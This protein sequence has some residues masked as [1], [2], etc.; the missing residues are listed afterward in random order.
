MLENKKISKSD[1]EQAVATPIDDGLQPLQH[2]STNRK[3][4]DNY[5]KEVIAEVEEKTGKNVYTDGLDIYTNLDMAAQQKLYDIINTG[6]Y[7][8]VS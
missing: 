6:D 4:I 3:V 8:S 2:S 1:Y 7:V 5:I